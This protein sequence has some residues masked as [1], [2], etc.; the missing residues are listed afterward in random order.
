ML[1]LF[2]ISVKKNDFK[3]LKTS[4]NDIL[5]PTAPKTEKAP[6]KGAL[7]VTLLMLANRNFFICVSM[8]IY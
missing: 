8:L 4:E 5:K 1:V 3:S 2:I 6:V 7:A